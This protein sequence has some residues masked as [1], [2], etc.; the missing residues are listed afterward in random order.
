MTSRKVGMVVGLLVLVCAVVPAT[1]LAEAVGYS[2]ETEEVDASD[3]ADLAA[4]PHETEIVVLPSGRRPSIPHETAFFLPVGPSILNDVEI[5][6]FLAGAE[7]DRRLLSELRKR[8]PDSRTEAEIFLARLKELAERAD[9]VR[10]A[11]RANRVLEQ[12]TIYYDWLE[13][14]FETA[15]EE[16]YE[17]YIGGAQGFSR[18]LEEF[19][20]AVLLTAMNRLDT[21]ARA[22]QEAYS[23]QAE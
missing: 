18:A 4:E 10:L 21:A 7:A 20:N 23:G 2:G 11:P 16:I 22:L 6:R 17:Y 8:V 13:T 19:E 5:E 9:P 12:A 14:E 15:E 1:G 3:E